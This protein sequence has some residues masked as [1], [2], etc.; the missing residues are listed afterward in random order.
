M[1]Q[2][3]MGTHLAPPRSPFEALPSDSIEMRWKKKIQRSLSNR[4]YFWPPQWAKSRIEQLVKNSARGVTKANSVAIAGDVTVQVGGGDDSVAVGQSVMDFLDGY[5]Y[6]EDVMGELKFPAEEI[7]SRRA[8]VKW[9]F[10]TVPRLSDQA[11]MHCAEQFLLRYHTHRDWPA[12]AA[13]ETMIWM[14]GVTL[15]NGSLRDR[16]Q[17]IGN[18][19][20]SRSGSSS[21]KKRKRKGKSQSDKKEKSSSESRSKDPPKERV[22]GTC[23][24]RTDKRF[25]CR[26]E[27]DGG[28]GKGCKYKHSCPRCPG[29]DHPASKCGK[30]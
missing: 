18:S 20:K 30:M 11:R 1:R 23:D 16:A 26:F 7:R 14:E 6:I 12:A 19:A 24:S 2:V 10:W 29:E 15:S 25:T 5:D 3:G 27:R 21:P 8:F 13:Q 28:D 4:E 17:I 22:P 9:L